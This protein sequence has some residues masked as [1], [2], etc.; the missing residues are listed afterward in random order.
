MVCGLINAEIGHVPI[1]RAY[2]T[3]GY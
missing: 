1:M 2:R 3:S